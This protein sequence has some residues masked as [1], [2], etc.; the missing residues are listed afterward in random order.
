MRRCCWGR[1]PGRCRWSLGTA[2]ATR[3]GQG[4]CQ[5]TPELVLAVALE[6]KDGLRQLVPVDPCGDDGK[7]HAAVDIHQ[8]RRLRFSPER[9]PRQVPDPP[10]AGYAE[11]QVLGAAADAVNGNGQ[12]QQLSGGGCQH[13]RLHAAAAGDALP[14]ALRAAVTAAGGPDRTGNGSA[15][16]PRPWR[17]AVADTP[18]SSRPRHCRRRVRAPMWKSQATSASPGT[19]DR[20]GP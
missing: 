7:Y 6:R 8:C 20:S 12:R 18:S 3:T 2:A 5:D 15:G 1:A 13:G 14:G 19:R 4:P 10:F 17:G 9:V 16:R 11:G